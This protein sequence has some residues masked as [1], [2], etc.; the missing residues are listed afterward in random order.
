MLWLRR[1]ELILCIILAAALHISLTLSWVVLIAGI[2]VSLL[3]PNL[4][5]RL[6]L[7]GRAPLKW[8]LFA[9]FLAVIL[10]TLVNGGANDYLNDVKQIF[11]NLRSFVV[12]FYIYQAFASSVDNCP[13]KSLG[14]FLFVGALAGLYGSIQQIF[15]FHPFTYPYLQ[16]TGFLQAPMPFAGLMQM[17]FF[18]SLGLLLKGGYTELPG[19]LKKKIFFA[20]I[21]IANFMGL[22]FSCERSAWLGMTLGIMAVTLR[23]SPRAFIKVFLTSFFALVIAWFCVPA[24]QKRLAPL[25]HPE[26]DVSVSA[27]MKIWRRSADIFLGHQLVGIGPSHFPHITDIPEALVPGRS[28]ELDHAHSNYMQILSTLGIVGFLAFLV[29]LAISLV[30]A[31]RL[32]AGVG[33]TGGL[34]LGT[35][36]ALVSLMVAG[37][38]EYNFGAGQVK[39]AQWFLIGALN[40]GKD[41]KSAGR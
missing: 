20:A 25:A 41:S 3:R 23:L 26:T 24:V 17:T 22:F 13:Q 35:F 29:L 4:I 7:L 16:G 38:F 1:L 5:E 10:S 28:T 14:T 2:V 33:W 11:A 6:K 30:V 9:F 12:Y 36:G 18:L 39:L 21:V 27:R 34:G 32:A 19:L 8:P 40:E 15:N 31:L 37:I